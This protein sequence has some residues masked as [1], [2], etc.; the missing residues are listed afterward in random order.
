MMPESHDPNWSGHL[1]NPGVTVVVTCE[2]P[3]WAGIG[4][5]GFCLCEGVWGGGVEEF[6]GVALG[7]AGTVRVGT[8]GP[9]CWMSV[10]QR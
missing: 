1:P 5:C 10:G 6:D 7:G 3:C 8:T 9:S 2:T 4:G